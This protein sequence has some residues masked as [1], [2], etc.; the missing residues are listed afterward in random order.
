MKRR[1]LLGAFAA[2]CIWVGTHAAGAS[3]RIAFLGVTPADSVTTRNTLDGFRKGL[4][5][6]GLIEGRDYTIE[7]AAEP[8][9]AQ[10]GARVAELIARKPALLVAITTPAAQ[11]AAR[12]TR[13]IPV[14]FGVVSD[15]VGSGIV[16]SLARPGGNVTGV[17]NM[18]PALSGKLLELARALLPGLSRAAVLWNPDNP[19][20]V[21]EAEEL[22]IA[23]KSTGVALEEL[24]ARSAGE[25]ERAL[26]PGKDRPKL[27]VILGETLTQANRARIAQLALAGR[28]AVVSNLSTHT[29]AGGVL[30]YSPDYRELN[31]RLGA[32]AARILK[33]ARP[34]DLPVELPT[35]FELLVNL[36][37]AKTLGIQVPQTLLLRA[38]RVIE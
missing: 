20:K 29:Q 9:I 1:A 12:A 38:D 21:I 26:A 30:S 16:T 23:A 33:G 3:Q 32:F 34:E 24:P 7:F 4:T 17:S 28:M 13:D 11:A 31:R 6:H 19:A 14:V 25:I 22:R 2:L 10:L 18:L 15:P 8:R 36:K 37:A 35:R 5:E 27:L